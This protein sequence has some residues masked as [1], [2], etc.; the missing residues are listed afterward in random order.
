M[1]DIDTCD[2]DDSVLLDWR[3][4]SDLQSTDVRKEIN[5]EKNIDIAFNL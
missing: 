1:Y 5:V 2:N 4:S 3:L